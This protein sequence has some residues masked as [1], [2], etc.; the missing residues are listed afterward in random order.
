MMSIWDTVAY[1]A[2]SHSAALGIAHGV[3]KGPIAD[4][5]G[6]IWWCQSQGSGVVVETGVGVCRSRPFCL[7]SEWELESVKFGRL[8]SGPESQAYTWQQRMIL[9][10]RLRTAR[11][12]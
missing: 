11:N 6:L 12:H 9:E 3:A 2:N 4:E 7:E 8:R 10:E 1:G 5:R